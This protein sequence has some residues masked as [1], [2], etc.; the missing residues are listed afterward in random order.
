MICEKCGYMLSHEDLFCP[1]CGHKIKLEKGIIEEIKKFVN[2][3][4]FNWF[5][6]NNPI[7]ILMI[8]LIVG[9]IIG[10]F[11]IYKEYNKKRE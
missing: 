5:N 1:N 9:A 6:T 3:I 10:T 11:G 4:K 7:K 8:F 2:K